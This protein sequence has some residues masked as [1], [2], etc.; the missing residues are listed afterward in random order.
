MPET[1]PPRLVDI[2]LCHPYPF[3]MGY[4]ALLGGLLVFSG[5]GGAGVKS[6]PVLAVVVA[7]AVFHFGLPRMFS[8][9]LERTRCVRRVMRDLR[10][11]EWGSE[12]SI[13]D[14][15]SPPT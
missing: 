4:L 9:P 2:P 5:M 8:L 1:P 15:I 3:V 13:D 7:A 10:N 12:P 11:T 14:I 6:P